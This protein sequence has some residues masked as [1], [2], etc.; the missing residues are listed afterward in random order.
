MST[1][2][3][4]TA[5]IQ[6]RLP[7]LIGGG[8]EQVT[9]KLVAKYADA[10]NLGGGID[11]VRHKE[12]VLLRHCEAVGRDPNEIER[13]SGLGVVVIRDSRDEART[14]ANR[15]FARNGKA[16]PWKD[17]PVGTPED[18][19]AY[20]APYLEIGYRHLIAG[21]PNPYDEES[22]TRMATEVRAAAGTSARGEAT[23]PTHQVGL[24]ER[25]VTND[26]PRQQRVRESQLTIEPLGTEPTN[27]DR[28]C[29]HKGDGH[30]CDPGNEPRFT[31]RQKRG[32][33]S[34]DDGGRAE[35]RCTRPQGRL[36]GRMLD[37]NKQYGPDRD[38]DRRRR[39]SC[40]ENAHHRPKQSEVIPKP[41]SRLIRSQ[42]S[43]AP[44]DHCVARN[45]SSKA[46][47]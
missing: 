34:R 10:N 26:G 40:D 8:G 44:A 24:V 43:I 12:E 39:D 14:V 7:L 29:S 41:L 1:K 33:D 17:Q 28:R 11:K 13:T 15:V 47:R 22:M 23:P 25:T 3:W 37:A 30:N 6:K 36:E 21:F 18:V 20:I 16:E 46:P 19:A 2:C 35:H 4:L 27:Q 5:P 45:R 9:L 32:S 31:A 38:E 42:R